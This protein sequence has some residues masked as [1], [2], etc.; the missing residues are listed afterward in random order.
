METRIR[1]G[2]VI[3]KLPHLADM[4]SLMILQP[5]SLNISLGNYED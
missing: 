1:H 4:K 3:S 5:E 2:T